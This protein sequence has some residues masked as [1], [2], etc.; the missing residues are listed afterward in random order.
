MSRPTRTV[1]TVAGTDMTETQALAYL[2]LN[3][4]VLVKDEA[5]LVR[6]IAALNDRLEATRQ[7]IAEVDHGIDVLDR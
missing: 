4:A 5:I 3:R 1:R 7:R 2:R 6:E